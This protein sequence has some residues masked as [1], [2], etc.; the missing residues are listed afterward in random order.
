MS[1]RYYSLCVKTVSC[2]S[3]NGFAVQKCREMNHFSATMSI[4]AALGASSV[5]RLALTW[6]VKFYTTTIIVQGN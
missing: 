6:S 1:D 5:D 2:N 4:V 3:L